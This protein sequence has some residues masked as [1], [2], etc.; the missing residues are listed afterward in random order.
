MPEKEV[1]TLA[2]TK[3]NKRIFDLLAL[4]Y[5]VAINEPGGSFLVKRRVFTQFTRKI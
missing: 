5:R 1:S 4:H 3:G 2:D